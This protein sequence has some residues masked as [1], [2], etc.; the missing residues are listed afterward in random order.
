MAKLVAGVLLVLNLGGL[1]YLLQGQ[2][3]LQRQL[4]QLQERDADN[5][6]HAVASQ[7][8]SDSR[9]T[10]EHKVAPEQP[11]RPSSPTDASAMIE[12]VS[13]APEQALRLD[14]G[15]D[16][17]IDDIDY[18]STPDREVID[19]GPDIDVEDIYN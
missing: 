2:F 1:A 3:E 18:V 13:M 7:E 4:K 15:D 10:M 6:P 8:R 5:T 19:I 17:N 16:I 12:K 9:N 14:I 11:K